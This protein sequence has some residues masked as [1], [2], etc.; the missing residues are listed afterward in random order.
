MVWS[1]GRSCTVDFRC[2]CCCS[3]CLDVR[4]VASGG[5]TAG[6]FHDLLKGYSC[7]ERTPV[8]I[9]QSVVERR[10]K[11]VLIQ[12]LWLRKTMA[13]ER[14]I[15]DRSHKWWTESAQGYT[16]RLVLC[17]GFGLCR[18]SICRAFCSTNELFEQKAKQRQT[19]A[20]CRPQAGPRV[21]GQHRDVDEWHGRISGSMELPDS[22][23]TKD[24]VW[25]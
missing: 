15:A 19:I 7:H 4:F 23:N 25:E 18:R 22:Q 2:C 5:V 13:I 24:P 16:R 17:S 8:F 10:P 20:W 6:Q 11:L 21:L 12:Q 1:T 3:C 14:L 9:H